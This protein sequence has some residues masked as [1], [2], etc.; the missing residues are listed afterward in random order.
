MILCANCKRLWP[1]GTTWCGN[2]RHT[3]GKRI[4]PDGHISPVYSDCCSTCGSSKLTPGAK[5]LNLRPVSFFVVVGVIVV[6]S[7]TVLDLAALGFRGV[8]VWFINV[9]LE[10]LFVLGLFSWLAGLILGERARKVIRDLLFGLAR[11][12]IYSVGYVA[13][14]FERACKR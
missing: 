6:L 12:I 10:R 14:L 7:P 2:C 1:E 4:C 3:L 5:S 13:K 8:Y 11:L 9:V